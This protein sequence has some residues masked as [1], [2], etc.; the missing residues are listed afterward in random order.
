MKI[1]SILQAPAIKILLFLYARGEVR[2][3]DL[4]NLIPSRGT[5]SVNL[6]ELEEEELIKRRVVAT[7]P[8]ESYYSLSGKGREVATRFNEIQQI[9]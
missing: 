7:K 8:I 3:T 4:S 6:K 5:L 2:Y 9:M 1:S